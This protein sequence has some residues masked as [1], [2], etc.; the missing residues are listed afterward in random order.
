MF[1]CFLASIVSLMTRG[2]R[3]VFTFCYFY[4]PLRSSS[5]SQQQFDS[6]QFGAANGA[7]LCEIKDLYLM[8]GKEFEAL[9]EVPAG[10][11][12]GR[13]YLIYL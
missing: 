3:A 10:N 5:S 7:V 2:L 8:M 6:Q 9:D 4:V 11:M 1:Y 13:D 12:I